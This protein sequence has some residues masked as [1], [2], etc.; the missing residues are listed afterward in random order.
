MVAAV[1]LVMPPVSKGG[2]TSSSVTGD[3]RQAGGA[4]LRKAVLQTT[5]LETTSTKRRNCFV[6]EDAVG[7]S[8]VGDDLLSGIEFSEARFKLAQRDIHGGWQMS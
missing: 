1:M 2:E 3:D 4:P 7:A 8:A 5:R 6:R